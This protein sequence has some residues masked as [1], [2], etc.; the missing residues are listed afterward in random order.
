MRKLKVYI[1]TFSF[2]LI[3]IHPLAHSGGFT[4]EKGIDCK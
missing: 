3:A 4:D 2:Q 1:Y